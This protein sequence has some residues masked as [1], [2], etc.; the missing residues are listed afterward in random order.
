MACP[1]CNQT[2]QCI[3]H[4]A[5][6]AIWHC[7]N[8]GTLKT[9]HGD[10]KTG[11][12]SIALPKTMRPWPAKDGPSAPFH[13]VALASLHALYADGMTVKDEEAALRFYLKNVGECREAAARCKEVG[14]L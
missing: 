14:I 6:V 13:L 12:R 5:N 3:H 10:A 8:C 1:A 4:A 11:S 7:P 2:M 9:R